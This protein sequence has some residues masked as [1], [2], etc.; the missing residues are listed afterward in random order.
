[1]ES[2][3]VGLTERLQQIP[4]SVI[5]APP[6]EIRSE[7]ISAVEEDIPLIYEVVIVGTSEILTFNICTVPEPHELFATTEMIPPPEPAVAFIEVEPEL[8]LQPEGNVQVY[9]VAP[10]TAV[11]L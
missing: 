11:I 1:L 9:E 4:L 10:G 7:I 2:D 3:N 6:S 5:S 8:P